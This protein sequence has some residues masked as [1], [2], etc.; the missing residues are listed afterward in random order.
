LAKNCVSGQ[1]ENVIAVSIKLIRA[2][3]SLTNQGSV[4]RKRIGLLEKGIFEVI[5][6]LIR[7]ERDEDNHGGYLKATSILGTIIV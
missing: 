2:L 7:G 1:G 3:K 5:K 6:Y 4:R